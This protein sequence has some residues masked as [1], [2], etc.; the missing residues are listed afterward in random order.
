VAGVLRALRWEAIVWRL[1]IAVSLSIA[2]PV[3][4]REIRVGVLIDG[5][6]A[7]ETISANT[8]EQAAKAVYGDG[9]TLTVA[10]QARLDGNWNLSNLTAALDH[11]ESDPQVDVVVTLGF[12]GSHLAAHR[13]QL[14]KP[15]IAA[16]VLDPVLYGLVP[17]NNAAC[18]T[19]FADVGTLPISAEC[20]G[21][22]RVRQVA[23]GFVWKAYR[24]VLGYVTVGP[25]V[26][27]V[28]D[29]TYTARDGTAA[30]TSNIMVYFT[31][32]YY[33]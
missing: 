7:R 25:E 20:G 15:T 8:L 1:A 17:D 19:N 12:T 32:R 21:V 23:G 5:P 31:I 9:L 3:S 30:E 14:P 11:L 27:Y 24:G 10:P 6:T 2:A 33:P 18:N 22:G 26:E 29:T 28:K 13:A 16:S 4:A